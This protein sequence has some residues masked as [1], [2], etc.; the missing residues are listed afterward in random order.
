MDAKESE[1]YLGI[2]L[3]SVL[4]AIIIG[5]F[6]I[7][8]FKQ[9]R[10]LNREKIRA[11]IYASEEEKKKIASDL[12]DDLGP[13]LATIKIYVNALSPNS[14]KDRD[15]VQHINKYLDG[16]IMRAKVIANGLMP[17]TLQRKG[18][19]KALEEYIFNIES[20]VQFKIDYV[21]PD[22]QLSLKSDSE[23]NIY[24]VIQEIITN[25]IRHSKASTLQLTFE[26]REDN[27]LIH[28]ADNG[29][30]FGYTDHNFVST[31]YGISNIKSRIEMLEGKYSI[32]SRPGE[33]IRYAFS[34]P[35]QKNSQSEQ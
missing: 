23:L 24:R 26:R 22:M 28:T 12:H 19:Q 9:H 4:L 2:L 10:K 21:F 25:T 1:V 13:I 29:I 18:L 30:G 15:L 27:L 20:Y 11:E 32:Y 7:S 34:I 31:G 33:G 6:T 3:F 35:L 5:A 8:Y 16:G 17:N 14:D